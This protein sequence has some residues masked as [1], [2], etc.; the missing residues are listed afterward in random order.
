MRKLGFGQSVVFVTPEEIA[1]KIRERTCKAADAQIGVEDVLCWSIGETWEDLKRSMPLWAVQGERFERTK[2]LLSGT[3]TT[4]EQAESF[5]EDEAQTLEVRYKP[6]PQGD[7]GGELL[8]RWNTTNPN[9][10]KVVKRCQDFDAMGFGTATLSEEQ[11]RELA[12]EIEEEKQ[13]ERPPR[14]PAEEHRVHPALQRLV[15]TG[16]LAIHSEAFKP[17]FQALAST[18][19]AKLFDT[20]DLPIDLLVTTDF[21]RTVKIPNS[22]SVTPFISDSYQRP[23]QFVLSVPSATEPGDTRRLIIISPFEANE[24]I[25]TIVKYARV[26]LH[27]FSPR[28]NAIYAPL[29]KLTLYNAGLEFCAGQI[30]RSTTFQLNLFAGSLYLRSFGEYSEICDFLGL[31]R[32]K[33][34]KDQRV[35]ADGFIEPPVGIWG[36][37]KSPVPF[38]RSLLMKIRREGEG[39]E[40][41]HLGKILNGV[42]LEKYEFTASS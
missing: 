36:L 4:L 27:L 28:A 26:T 16:H 40:K 37:Q 3:A 7:R 19:A 2:T 29:D 6:L 35:F 33:P 5:L 24:L 25:G 20:A 12:P 31:L 32:S 9:I 42:R 41:T 22:S 39:V 1:R 34:K 23:V 17:A 21:M 8:K 15:C 30:P 38:L 18:S 14:L 10:A 11:E 13:I